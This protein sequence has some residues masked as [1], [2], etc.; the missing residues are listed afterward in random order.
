MKYFSTLALAAIVAAGTICTATAQDD[1]LP[2]D[3][4]IQ[5]AIDAAGGIEAL[6][7]G[8]ILNLD[9]MPADLPLGLL[10]MVLNGDMPEGS[11]LAVEVF[12]DGSWEVLGEEETDE[13]MMMIMFDGFE[14]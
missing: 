12:E 14:F 2:S 3:A 7:D 5:K 9:E 1:N 11:M 6:E 4:E 10:D 13:L 8:A